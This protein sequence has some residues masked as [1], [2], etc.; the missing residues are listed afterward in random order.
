MRARASVCLAGN[1]D[2]VVVG[3]L[4]LEEFSHDAADAAGWSRQQLND[5]NRAYLAGLP[6][7]IERNG[8]LLA[9]GSPRDPVWEYVLSNDIALASL[10]ATD[11]P[12][13]LVGHSH[14]ALDLG[15]ADEQ[16]TGG[17]AEAGT[18]VDLDSGRWLLNPGSVGQPRDGDP[19]AAWLL[20]DLDAR[21]RH[22]RARRVRHRRDADG[23]PRGR[24][25]RAPGR[26][27]WRA[28]PSPRRAAATRLG[29]GERDALAAERE[30][31]LV[32]GRV[33]PP[34]DRGERDLERVGDLGVGHADDVAQEQRHL[35]VDVQLL[36]R[37]PERVDR[38]G[39][40]VGGVVDLER[41][42]V[43]DRHQ[44]ARPALERAE[45]V[46]HAV[47]RHLE[48]PGREAR[49]ER[50][51]RQPLVDAEEDLLG[52][53]LGEGAVADE[54][55]HVV[56]HRRLVRPDDDREGAL[57]PALR[58]LQDPEVRLRKCHRCL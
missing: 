17:L 36:D 26:C 40:L 12:L 25:A 54:P 34:L 48:H 19:R 18:A 9:H 33:D 24:A 11:A 32:A 58:L 55:E 29:A 8:A 47:L 2:L 27:G 20:L 4:G 53:I 52:Q 1:H 14:V 39:P 23:D 6:S 51:L 22:V 43:L 46:E 56:E 44:R 28:A 50:E 21:L 41:G 7:M 38:L 45:L 57:V 42:R 15:V 10:E 49:A 3:T 16:L 31:H 35:Q 30:L 13:V 37:A 5:E